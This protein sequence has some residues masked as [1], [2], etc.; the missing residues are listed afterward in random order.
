MVESAGVG[1]GAM[2]GRGNRRW[3]TT[4]IPA[5]GGCL[6]VL[7]VPIAFWAAFTAWAVGGADAPRHRDRCTHT[8]RYRCDTRSHDLSKSGKEVRLIPKLRL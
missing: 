4:M 3:Y 5:L 7:L 1:G 8:S 2:S 6:G